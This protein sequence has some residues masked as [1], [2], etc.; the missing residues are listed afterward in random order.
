MARRV[1]WRSQARPGRKS[2]WKG[3]LLVVL[4]LSGLAWV[5]WTIIGTV[6]FAFGSLSGTGPAPLTRGMLVA[7][8]DGALHDAGVERISGGDQRAGFERLRS[9]GL[10][11]R[12][13]DGEYHPERPVRRAEL[14]FVWGR[15]VEVLAWHCGASGENP[16]VRF[17][18]RVAGETGREC[19][20]RAD[21]DAL[22]RATEPLFK[23]GALRE[24]PRLQL[25]ELV[26]SNRAGDEPDPVVATAKDE[27]PCTKTSPA[28]VLGGKVLDALTGKPIAEAVLSVAGKA[29]RTG[30]E[31][32]FSAE[33]I[34]AGELLEYLV[35][36]DGYRSL[37]VKRRLDTRKADGVVFRLNPQ[38]AVLEGRVVSS[39]D[40]KPLS[41]IT[42]MIGERTFKTDG[43]GR[44]RIQGLKPGY[45]TLELT[46]KG[47]QKSRELVFIEEKSPARTLKLDP[48]FG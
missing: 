40:G 17:A 39:A 31:G 4:L 41:G 28:P 25:K 15:L 35:T 45:V 42:G 43:A 22:R 12:F 18:A 5:G 47:Y 6:A 1:E 19:A 11:E 24:S 21:L 16:V 27:R 13:P 14:G 20:T 10:I 38:R 23:G 48:T 29:L 44:F 9:R 2:G 30:A 36:A 46:G 26:Q 37:T 33:G 7:A 8:M 34:P 32:R 3:R